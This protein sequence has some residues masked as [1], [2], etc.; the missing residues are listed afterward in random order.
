[1]ALCMSAMKPASVW[2]YFHAVAAVRAGDA[3]VVIADVLDDLV[4]RIFLVSV[5]ELVGSEQ[6]RGVFDLHPILQPVGGGQPQPLG[7]DFVSRVWLIEVSGVLAHTDGAHDQ[8][9][10]F[11]VARRVAV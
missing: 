11:P 4:R 2:S 1:M 6:Y 10:S 3:V 5:G 7:D 9:I 8:R